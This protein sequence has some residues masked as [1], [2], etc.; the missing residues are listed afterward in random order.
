MTTSESDLGTAPLGAAVY[1]EQALAVLALRL[2]HEVA[3]TR[4]LRGEARQEGFLGLFLT[5]QDAQAML[6]ELAGR[7]SVGGGLETVAQ[8]E[9]LESELSR[10]RSAQPELVWSR[11]AAAFA[12]T[13]AELELVLCAAAPAIDPRYGRVYGFLNDDLGRRFLTPALAQRLLSSH[14]LDLATLRRCLAQD[15]PLQRHGLVKV[16]ETTPRSEA[17]ISVCEELI[18][19]L[20]GN[21]AAAG[22]VPSFSDR[23]E[24]IDGGRSEAGVTVLVGQDCGGAALLA[25]GP[26]ALL[27]LQ[28]CRVSHLDAST[29]RETVRATLRD[30]RLCGALPFLSGFAGAP[31]PLRAEI[32]LLVSAPCV[33]DALRLGSWAEA[34]LDA[35]EQL[36]T[37]LPLTA[38]RKLLGSTSLTQASGLPLL[39]RLELAR[40]FEATP[41]ALVPALRARAARSMEGLALAV[42]S[43]FGFDD[44]VL[45]PAALRRLVELVSWRTH[46]P[47]VLDEWGFGRVFSRRRGAVALFRGP[48]GTGKTMA[49]SIVANAMGL[50]LYRVDLAGLISKYIGET[51]KNLERVFAAAAAGDVVLFFDEADALFGKRSEVSD[52]HDRY[53]NIETSYL[54]QRIEAQDGSVILA[55]N[56]QDNIDAAFLRRIDVVVDFPAPGPADR[57]RLWE[58]LSA[59][60]A[61]LATDLDL[62]FLAE[63]FELTGGE[64]R[65]VLIAAAHAAAR[66]DGAIG[67]GEIVRALAQEWQ[68]LGRPLRRQMFGQ[69]YQHLRD[70]P[71]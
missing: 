30:A 13:D 53:A 38:Q 32:A 56:L 20:L 61:P 57:L 54:L 65:N 4:A 48:P 42:E 21:D 44:L 37:P 60:R 28:A 2:K 19:L 55:T 66:D 43:S 45:A 67:M 41:A 52:A 35:V 36:V 59:T 70:T 14:D 8:I 11:L 1:L 58:R 17:A 47:R 68:K 6:D 25:A 22:A 34:G 51:E 16:A 12:L 49:A 5:E 46:A 71:P 24:G 62:G 63:G 18:E 3:L 15:Q 9:R 39:D 10:L 23:F 40:R 7:V 27:R 69:H 31:L 64:I 50:P 29:L 33:L 26:R